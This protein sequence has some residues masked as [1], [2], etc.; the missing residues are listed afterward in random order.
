M[1]GGQTITV[2]T[3]TRTGDAGYLGLQGETRTATVI[4]GCHGRVLSS[5]ELDQ[6]AT[7]TGEQVWKWTCPPLGPLL[8]VTSTGELIFDGVTYQLHGEPQPKRDLAGNLSHVTLLARR[9]TG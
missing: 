4:A 3:I 5:T 9:Q 7:Q 1:I 2:V 6:T 8:E